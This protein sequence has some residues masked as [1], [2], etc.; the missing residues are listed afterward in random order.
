MAT[1]IDLEKAFDKIY[2]PFTIKVLKKQ[3]LEEVCFN[4]IKPYMA[5]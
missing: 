3:G 4:V 2:H 5:N 1:S